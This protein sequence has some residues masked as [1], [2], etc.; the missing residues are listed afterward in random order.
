VTKV[1]VVETNVAR[2]RSVTVGRIRDGVQEIIEGLKAGETVVV[3]GQNRL[4]DGTRSCFS[5]LN[6]RHGREAPRSR[7]PIRATPR[8]HES[9]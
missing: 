7:E 6:H 2:S 5:R 4:S 8:S 1:F 3:S 9:R